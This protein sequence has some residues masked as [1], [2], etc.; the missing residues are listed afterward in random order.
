MS[1]P[2]ALRPLRQ[3]SFRLL[4]AGQLTSNVGDA[5]YA[6]ALPWYVLATHGGALLLATVLTAYGIPRTVLVAVGGSASDRWRPWTVMMVADSVRAVLVA[7]LAVVAF[8]GP[9]SPDVLIPIAAVIGAGEGLFL[10]GSMAI[11]P[12]LVPD[13]DLQ[14]ANALSSG[15][16]Q[17][18][19]LVGPAIAGAVVATAG[20][21]TAFVVDAASFLVSAGSLAGIRQQRWRLP[22]AAEP[23]DHGTAGGAPS[24]APT[25]WRV[26][27]SERVLQLILLVILAANLG[28]G[29]LFE[30]AL[31]ALA[32]GPLHSGAAGYGGLVA[33][34]G[35]GAL[36]GSVAAA[37]AGRLRRPALVA[38]AAFLG[39]TVFMT[40]PPYLHSTYLAGVCLAL[41]GVL[42]GF[43]NIL[44]LTALQRWADPQLLGRVMGLIVLA[45]FGTFPLSVALAGAVVH[46]YGPAPFF[47]IA[48]GVLALALLVALSQRSWR[49]FGMPEAANVPAPAEVLT[50]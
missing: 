41:F 8:A 20:P 3:R 7:L 39:D 37:Q 42:N 9:A 32:H 45:S 40:V 43:G 17:L 5:F 44:A 47:P 49:T 1:A 34:I 27:R 12:S 36:V 30:V 14:A 18:A 24:G 25:L 46:A 22:S 31:P 28:T 35:A 50:L 38:S 2:E 11:V 19:A 16:T 33:S 4:T 6:V 26:L 48:G 13:D 15:G 23:A 10:P 21:A 29:G